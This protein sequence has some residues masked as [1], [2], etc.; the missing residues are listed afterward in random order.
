MTWNQDYSPLPHWVLSTAVSALP[1]FTLFFILLVLKKRVWVAALGG[2]IMAVLLASVVFHM[3]AML[4]SKASLLGFVFGLLRIAW[5]IVA[6]IFL[7][8]IAV[9]TGQFQRSEERRVGKECIFRWWSE[10]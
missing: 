6:S 10:S 2:M 1:V 9:E 8:H 4:I 5:I 7:Y 3:P